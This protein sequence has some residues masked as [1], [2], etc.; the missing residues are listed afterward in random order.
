VILGP[1]TP[2]RFEYDALLPG[3]GLLVW[4]V[5][6][7]VVPFTTALRP[8]E[9]FSFNTNFRRRGIRVIEAD[10]LEDLGDPGSPFIFG[11]YRDPWYVGNNASLSDSTR[12]DLRPNIG[13]RT[14]VRLDVFDPPGPVMRMRGVR[15]WSLPSWPVTIDAPDEGAQLLAVDADGD[16]TLEVCWAGGGGASPDSVSLFAVALNGTGI[17]GG[18]HVFAQLDRR[19]LQPIAAVATG[20]TIAGALRPGPAV[21]AVTTR[22]D[23]PDLSTQGGRVWLVDHQG[24]PLPGWPANLPTIAT[25]PAVIAGVWPDVRVFVGLANGRVVALDKDGATVWTSGDQVAGG[26]SGRLAV[27]FHGTDAWWLGFAGQSG[28]VAVEDWSATGCANAPCAWQLGLGGQGFAPELLWLD[29]NA[30]SGAA[31]CGFVLVAHEADRMWAL[32]TQDRAV[33]PGWGG[34]YRDTIVPGLAVGD[35]DGDGFPELVGRTRHGGVAYWNAT[36]SPS[37]GWPEPTARDGIAS[38]AP[39]IVVDVDGDA[40]PEIVSVDGAGVV[41]AL[42]RDATQPE[43]WP[44]ASGSGALGSALGADLDGDGR[45]ELVIPDRVMPD[46]LEFGLNGRFGTLYAFSLPGSASGGPATAFAWPMLGGDPGRTGALAPARATAAPA[47]ASGPY[48]SGSLKAYPNPA[49]RRP[50][51]FAYRLSEPAKVDFT[52]LD[53]SG[54]AVAT[55]SRDARQSDNLE[56][57]DPG[58][59]PAGLYLARLKFRGSLGG[60]HVETISVGVIK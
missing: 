10:A 38:A 27:R 37:P 31:E 52:I 57:W 58:Q 45:V 60:E 11:S 4:H 44:L 56:V 20:A 25:T 21:F 55:F 46:S 16:G 18:P 9:D 36:G 39:P 2:D 32:C 33:L 30:G 24:N 23:G 19:P 40:T 49:R 48:V 53:T 17:G 7:S 3:P 12:P 6:A 29:F 59:V 14:H 51:T 43:G 13:T 42:L 15:T 1:E 34:A 47:P 8:N 22:A 28:A 54:H 26:V 35:A 5:D 41:T 50:V